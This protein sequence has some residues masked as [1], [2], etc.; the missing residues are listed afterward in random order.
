MIYIWSSPYIL[1][2]IRNA[3]IGCSMLLGFLT[4]LVNQLNIYLYGRCK[5]TWSSTRFE[6]SSKSIYLYRITISTRWWGSIPGGHCF[7]ATEDDRVYCDD[8]I[9]IYLVFGKSH[10]LPYGP[11]FSRR[12][13]IYML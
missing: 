12:C 5:A 7:P 10:G 6:R 9:L 4:L 11:I 3:F 1:I 2:E 13:F 8:Y